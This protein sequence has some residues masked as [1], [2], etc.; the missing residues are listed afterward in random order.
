MQTYFLGFQRN[1]ILYFLMIIWKTFKDELSEERIPQVFFAQ[2]NFEA[3][4]FFGEFFVR[5][6][7]KNNLKFWYVSN[8]Q[9]S[10]KKFAKYE[11][12]SHFSFFIK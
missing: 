4:T 5:E 9:I 3:T 12:F 10:R 6:K 7:K 8:E 1:K 2:F 11:Q